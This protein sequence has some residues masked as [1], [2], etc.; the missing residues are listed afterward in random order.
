MEFALGLGER[1][2]VLVD[3]P[4]LVRQVDKV[5]RD[6]QLIKLIEHAADRLDAASIR[7]A[8]EPTGD[9]QLEVE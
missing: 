4:R 6:D 2:D 8:L 1:G 3:K 7:V 9:R 5:R